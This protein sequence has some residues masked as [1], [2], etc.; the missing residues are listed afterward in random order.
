MKVS[1]K[2]IAEALEGKPRGSGWTARCPAHNDT[3]PS[4]SV[5]ESSDGRVLIYCFAGCSQERVI[6]ALKRKGLW[7]RS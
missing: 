6:D 4:L 3:H 7:W 2:K 5:S 1:A